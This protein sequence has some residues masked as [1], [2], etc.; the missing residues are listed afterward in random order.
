[1]TPWTGG[2]LEISYFSELNFSTR[3]FLVVTWLTGAIMI[4][5][6]KQIIPM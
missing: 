3:F 2:S 6:D 5:R 1:M 4:L